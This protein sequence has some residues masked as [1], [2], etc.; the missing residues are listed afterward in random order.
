MEWSHF[1]L[2]FDVNFVTFH[3]ARLKIHSIYAAISSNEIKI[4]SYS[5]HNLEE[6][7]TR[8]LKSKN[9]LFKHHPARLNQT[10]N[11][12]YRMLSDRNKFSLFF[13]EAEM[14]LEFRFTMSQVQMA[15]G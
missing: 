4:H 2:F 14:F 9:P 8:E 15:M 12:A 7:L 13:R 1:V 11:V 6:A 10:K 3:Y 5:W